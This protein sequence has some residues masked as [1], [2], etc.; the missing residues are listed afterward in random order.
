MIDSAAAAARKIKALAGMKA[1]GDAFL[2]VTLSTSRLDDWRVS[3]P[4][5]LH[6][7]LTRLTQGNHGAKD[8]KRLLQSDLDYVL[9]VVAYEVTPETQ[10]LAVFVDGKGHF[11]ERIELP[12]RL[13]NRLLIEPYPYVRP[14]AHALALLEP[15]VLARVSRDESSLYLIDEWGVAQEDDHAGPWLRTSDRE[16][17]EVSIKEYFAAARQEA[18]VEQHFK[19]VGASL[20]KL[21]EASKVRRVALCAQHDIASAFRRALPQAVAA[22][23]VAEIPFDAAATPAQMVAAARQAVEDA[24]NGEMKALASRIKEGLG[25][26][27]RGVSGF[28][29]VIAAVG[30]RQVQTLLVDRNF[31]D[32]GWRCP[33]C[34]WA[35]LAEV[36]VCPVCGGK[37]QPVVDAVGEI[38]RQAI[39][40]NVQ[41][42]VGEQIPE[43]DDLKGVGGLLRYA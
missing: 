29:D 12:F 22:H 10:G 13:L 2:T 39:L 7:E 33:A 32:P 24:R 4:S 15:F 35:G 28:D 38:V 8:R 9:D 23:I 11:S 20:A 27:G 30:R 25:R 19:E 36:A 31:R 1:A 21:L 16:T 18:L 5:F 40:Q 34:D 37:P 42:E 17:G 43:L 3:V 41:V 26:G 6:S 14:V